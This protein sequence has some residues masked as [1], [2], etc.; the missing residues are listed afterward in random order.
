MSDSTLPILEALLASLRGAPGTDGR[1]VELDTPE[2]VLSWRYA[3]EPEWRPV[4]DLAT[5]RGADGLDGKD[6]ENG[7]DGIDGT[8]GIDGK[9]GI[10]GVN[11]IDGQDGRDGIDGVNGKDGVDGAPSSTTA[12]ATFL[13]GNL[14]KNGTTDCGPI[15]QALLDA[16]RS[17]FTWDTTSSDSVY[18]FNTSVFFD[19]PDVYSKLVIEGNG[20]KIKAGPNLCTTDAFSRSTDVKWVF[21]NNTKKSARVG[22]KVTVSDATRA[23]GAQTGGLCRLYISHV[24]FDG[25]TQRVGLIFGNRTSAFLTGVTMLGGYTLVSWWEY[26]DTTVLIQPQGR[27]VSGGPTDAALVHQI[28]PGDGLKI[29]S[30]KVDPTIAV[31]N[32]TSCNGGEIDADVTARIILTRCHGMKINMHMEGRDRPDPGL[33]I[34]NSVVEVNASTLYLRTSSVAMIDVDDSATPDD[35]SEVTING[36]LTVHDISSQETATNSNVF[37]PNEIAPLVRLSGYAPGTI[38]R[39]NGVAARTLTIGASNWM[40]G[41]A[42]RLAST[43]AVMQTILSSPASM[44]ALAS[45]S[46]QL[47]RSRGS[48]LVEGLGPVADTAKRPLAAPVVTDISAMTSGHKGNHVVGTPIYYVYA[49]RNSAGQ[50]TAAVTGDGTPNAYYLKHLLTI[51]DYPAELVVWRRSSPTGAPNAWASF[52][53]GAQRLFLFDQGSRISG[54]AWSTTNIPA[55]P[56]ADTTSN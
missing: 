29:I 23:T 11:G 13:S 32:L 10:D 9:D 46:W 49:L 25:G 1:E 27:F 6:G 20:A 54:V 38:I 34:R 51:A 14:P 24:T 21:F 42:A 36:G 47:S 2:G 19:D 3:G 16:G 44:V 4:I 35:P 52:S 26:S 12:T 48:F 31:A 15:M 33:L 28:T 53:A 18:Y 22:S 5:L 43:A 7:R 50:F 45:G 41:P 55:I 8:N 40:S 37:T 39:A 30:P 17:S 56:T